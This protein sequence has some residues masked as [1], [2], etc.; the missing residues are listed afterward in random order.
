VCAFFL[1]L[2]LFYGLLYKVVILV[3]S[4]KNKLNFKNNTFFL[5]SLKIHF[6]AAKI[7]S[8]VWRETLNLDISKNRI[9]G[10]FMTIDQIH[11][12]TKMDKFD[13]SEI[14]TKKM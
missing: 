5:I 6:R 11:L 12:F 1:Y 14:A 9:F 8:G 7:L 3:K 4:I 2:T 10:I 13:S